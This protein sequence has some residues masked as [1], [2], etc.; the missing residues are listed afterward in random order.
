MGLDAWTVETDLRAYRNVPR[1]PR[2]AVLVLH[3]FGEHAGRYARTLQHFSDA[4]IAAYA[5]DHRG[6]GQ[7]PGARALVHRFE[8]LVNDSLTMRERVAQTHPE[9]PHFLLGASMGGVVA[10]RSVQRRPD[11]LAGAI[12]VSPALDITGKM[13]RVMQQLAAL[14]GEV[15]PRL[16]VSTIDTRMLAR[17]AAVG[18]AYVA[19]PLVYHGSV[20]AR[21]AAEMVAAGRAAFADA[22]SW[23]IATLIIQGQGDRIVSPRGAQRFAEAIPIGDVTLRMIPDGYHEPFNDAGGEALADDVV[24]WMMSRARS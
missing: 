3:G 22:A 19:D 6:H 24:A 21:S 2:A 18:E 15:A 16:P 5:Y 7:S 23:R 17:D 4:G 12:L 1:D 10:V 13:P 11:G 9:L 8:T 20:P 14:A